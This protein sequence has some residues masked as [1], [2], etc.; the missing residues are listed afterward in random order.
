MGMISIYRFIGYMRYNANEIQK[1]FFKYF[2]RQK[3]RYLTVPYG[4]C[5]SFF[6]FQIQCGNCMF[7]KFS[8]HHPSI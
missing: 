6:F 8:S 4:V 3:Y 2:L 5:F 1:Y 7:N